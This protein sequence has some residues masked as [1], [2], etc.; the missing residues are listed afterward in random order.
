MSIFDT[1]EIATEETLR[2]VSSELVT[3]SATLLS[4]LA[5][6]TDVHNTTKH[7]LANTP[8]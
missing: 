8:V 1:E 2:R 4:I 6:L 7:S 3:I 5:I